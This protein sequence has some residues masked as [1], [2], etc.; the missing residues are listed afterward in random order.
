MP[1]RRASGP[2]GS[3][4]RSSLA[5]T[6]RR[7]RVNEDSEAREDSMG[8]NS[9]G[10]AGAVAATAYDRPAVT[11][12]EHHGLVAVGAARFGTGE[13]GQFREHG[14]VVIFVGG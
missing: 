12:K 3:R 9:S 8:G 4:R 2:M 5:I 1:A 14:A 6:H 13:T 7:R 10:L 11:R